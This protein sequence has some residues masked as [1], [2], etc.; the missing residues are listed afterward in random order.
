MDD[1]LRAAFYEEADEMFQEIED[2]L[3]A[4]DSKG[5]TAEKIDNLFRYMHTLK[6]SSAAME[7]HDM[8]KLTHYLEDILEKVREGE[9]EL[10]KGIIDRMFL[11]LDELRL[12]IT[13]HKNDQAYEI[14]IDK[15]IL[16]LETC[17]SEGDD[18]IGGDTINALGLEERL[19]N[20]TINLYHDSDAKGARLYIVADRLKE[21]GRICETSW[22]NMDIEEIDG[23]ECEHHTT[24]VAC[25]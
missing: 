22:G 8:A 6:G 12:R 17:M 20:I 3:L 13:K 7:I 11:S 2:C 10:S 24:K 1:I 21:K 16:L 23:Q 25:F 5:V 15:H 18:D 9:L 14:D 19:Y 4:M